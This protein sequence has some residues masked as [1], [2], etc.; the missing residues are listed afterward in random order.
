MMPICFYIQS[1]LYR[2]EELLKSK[3]YDSIVFDKSKELSARVDVAS[4]Y[5]DMYEELFCAYSIYRKAFITFLLSTTPNYF[6]LT[7]ELIIFGE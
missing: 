1:Y 4:M 6:Q 5:V 7:K 2:Q 3:Y